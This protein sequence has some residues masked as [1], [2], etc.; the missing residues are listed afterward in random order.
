MVRGVARVLVESCVS[1]HEAAL[2]E[3]MLLERLEPPFNRTTGVEAIAGVRL[4]ATPPAIGAVV[5]LEA[6][7]ERLF[8]PYLGWAPTF[9]AAAAL[10]RL[11][12]LHFCRPE[13]ELDSVQRD[14]A[15]LRGVSVNDLAA[16]SA[17]AADVLERDPTA[18]TAAVERV[19]HERDH[20][21]DMRLYERAADLQRQI[22][23]ILWIAQPQ[24]VM[25][26]AASG[27]R[28]IADEARIGVVTASIA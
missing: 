7:M 1:E 26:L 21:S 25:T 5:D 10:S 4:G 28:W 3:R 14:I 8:G 27:D 19:R 20:A 24:S 13:T 6:G 16:L 2:L 9:A 11:F 12:P 17:Q 18:V 22:D 23:G 15:R